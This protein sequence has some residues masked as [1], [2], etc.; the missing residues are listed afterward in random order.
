MNDE[1]HCFYFGCMGIRKSCDVYTLNDSEHL[2][3]FPFHQIQPFS[4]VYIKTDALYNLYKEL[5]RI[6]HPFI[7]ITGCSDHSVPSSRV[8]S[9]GLQDFDHLL[10]HPK[11]IHIFAQNCTI[12]HHKITLMPI[13]MD[14]H[15]LHYKS[16][17]AWGPN[18]SPIEQEMLLMY[19]RDNAAPMWERD[20]QCYSNFHLA[21]RGQDRHDALA[22]IPRNLVYYEPGPIDRLTTWKHQSQYA[23]VISPHGNGMDCHRTWEA[24]ALGCIPIVRTSPLD[25]LYENLPVLIVHQ[26]SDVTEERLASTITSFMSRS[27]EMEKLTLSYWINLIRI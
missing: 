20:L 24:L 21:M 17:P 19:I 15:T 16:M 10:H 2:D 8:F 7:L 22:N 27:F 14:Y 26:W 6:S 5:N 1:E 23:F 13:G 25:P 11:I 12:Q 3:H 18:A 4:V 9:D